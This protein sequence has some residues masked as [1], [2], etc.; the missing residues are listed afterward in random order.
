MFAQTLQ[1]GAGQ[2]RENSVS[3]SARASWLNTSFATSGSM[4]RAVFFY[5]HP[6]NV[7]FFDGRRS[8]VLS[9]MRGIPTT[10]GGVCTPL[11]K[12]LLFPTPWGAAAK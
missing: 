6:T 1:E 5:G 2:P 3:K 8:A 7:A 4:C 10:A 12:N 9:W 11:H